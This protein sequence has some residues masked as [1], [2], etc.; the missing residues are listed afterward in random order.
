[1]TIPQHLQQFVEGAVASGK[2]RSPEE[3]LSTALHLLQ[4]RERKLNALRADIRLGIEQLERG[5]GIPILDEAAH[6]A[7]FD[8]IERRGQQRLAQKREKS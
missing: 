3:V 1:M 2:Y 4:E 8:D 6:R 5:E 7:F